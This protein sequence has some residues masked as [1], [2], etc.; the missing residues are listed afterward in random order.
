MVKTEHCWQCGALC[1]TDGFGDDVIPAGYFTEDSFLCENCF[2]AEDYD[3]EGKYI[4][5]END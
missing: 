2:R 4:G 3:E 1:Y 5:E